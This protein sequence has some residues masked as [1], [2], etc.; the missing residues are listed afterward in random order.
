MKYVKGYPCK[1]RYCGDFVFGKIV[2]KNE[3]AMVGVIDGEET[4]SMVHF[5]TPY[6]TVFNVGILHLQDLDDGEDVV[7]K[8]AEKE[9]ID[10]FDSD[11]LQLYG[12]KL[13]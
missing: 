1:M 4:S 10:A 11:D 9:A 5:S 2:G 12:G 3:D 6:G 8:N 13:I 7:L